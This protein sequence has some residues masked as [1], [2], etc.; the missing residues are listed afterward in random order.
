MNHR[1]ALP[2]V[3]LATIA[4]AG[5]GAT[6]EDST[7]DFKGEQRA[8]AQTVEDLQDAGSSRDAEKICNDLLAR[9]LQTQVKGRAASCPEGLDDSLE[10]ADAFD[11]DV[12]KVTVN[13]QTATATVEAGTGERKRRETLTLVQ[14]RNVWKLS[15]LGG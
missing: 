6:V 12:K 10:D 1:F 2:A 14:E 9:E 8:V 3:L 4:A 15:S 13:G 11:L 5:C 7:E